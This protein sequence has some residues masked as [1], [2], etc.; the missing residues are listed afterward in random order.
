VGEMG[1]YSSLYYP[2]YMAEWASLIRD[3]AGHISFSTG[4]FAGQASEC[5]TWIQEPLNAIYCITASGVMIS[6][7]G[8]SQ[9]TIFKLTT[10]SSNVPGSDFDLP[11]GVVAVGG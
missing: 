2:T 9:G 7:G 3:D 1:A 4:T 8:N 5:V 11:P 6:V 10:Y